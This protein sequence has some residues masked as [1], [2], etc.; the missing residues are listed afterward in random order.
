MG[1]WLEILRLETFWSRRENGLKQ[2]F[3]SGEDPQPHS[4]WASFLVHVPV[5]EAVHEQGSRVMSV[6]RHYCAH[7]RLQKQAAPRYDSAESTLLVMANSAPKESP[8]K[9]PTVTLK[10]LSLGAGAS[11]AQ[12]ITRNHKQGTSNSSQLPSLSPLPVRVPTDL[13]PQL[14][15]PLPSSRPLCGLCWWPMCTLLAHCTLLSF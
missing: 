8:E 3:L 1:S 10:E 14:L 5:H 13:S 12:G 15:P 7:T 2:S 4:V 6:R 9:A 11:Y